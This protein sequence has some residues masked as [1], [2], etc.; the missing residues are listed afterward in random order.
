MKRTLKFKEMKA[1]YALINKSLPN[2]LSGFTSREEMIESI[3]FIRKYSVERRWM[4]LN[5]I[6]FEALD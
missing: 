6:N 4:R 3:G 2:E 1:H 5:G